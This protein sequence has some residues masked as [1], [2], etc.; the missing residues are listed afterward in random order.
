MLLSNTNQPTIT[1]SDRSFLI[2][3]SQFLFFWSQR[4]GAGW[5]LSKNCA[6]RKK[7]NAITWIKKTF[8]VKNSFI[9]CLSLILY[10]SK[11]RMT[12]LHAKNCFKV[13]RGV[14][15]YTIFFRQVWPY[16]FVVRQ[17]TVSRATWVLI[18]QGAQ[19]LCLPCAILRGTVSCNHL[20]CCASYWFFSRIS[21]VAISLR[22]GI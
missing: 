17:V 1:Q 14:K 2:S 19:S 20:Y 5:A 22:Q 3:S 7:F 10:F 13:A 9:S 11:P 21:S 4:A 15:S 16:G 8:S 18:Q 12:I 6:K